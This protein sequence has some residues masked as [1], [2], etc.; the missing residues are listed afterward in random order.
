MREILITTLI[1]FLLL[2]VVITIGGDIL[3]DRV[4][5]FAIVF[6]AGIIGISC[7]AMWHLWQLTRI[8]WFMAGFVFFLL[9]II[10]GVIDKIFFNIAACPIVVAGFAI[11]WIM[12]LRLG[13]PLEKI[14]DHYFE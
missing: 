1:A 12:L 2:C 6:G 5:A 14:Y 13:A 10:A 4:L 7:A 3:D 8:K 11:G 9:I